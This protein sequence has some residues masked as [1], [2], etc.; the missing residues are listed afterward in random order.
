MTT[1]YNSSVPV[2]TTRRFAAGLTRSLP[3]Y[4]TPFTA[5]DLDWLAD[6]NA[7]RAELDRIVDQMFA[8]AEAVRLVEAGLC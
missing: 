4:T 1:L 6:D 5:S 8:E 7:N 3:T 2:K